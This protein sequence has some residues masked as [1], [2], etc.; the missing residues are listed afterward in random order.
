MVRVKSVIS[1]GVAAF[2]FVLAA[3][4][5]TPLC[6]AES[7]APPAA[8]GDAS[9][10]RAVFKNAGCGNCHTLADASGSGQIGPALDGDANL[11]P[12]L[13]IDR[14]TNGQGGMPPFGGQ[15]SDAD[16]ADVTAYVIHAAAK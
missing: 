5:W 11:T 13:V 9:K 8:A 6:A 4:A 14:V 10:G 12:A 7:A 16:I 3:A 15:L 2:G 1:L